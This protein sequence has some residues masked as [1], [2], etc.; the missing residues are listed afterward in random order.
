MCM[1]LQTSGW[2]ALFFAAKQ[3]NLIIV[4]ELIGG[5]ASV[6]I[7][8]K[9]TESVCLCELERDWRK[10]VGVGSFKLSS[11]IRM[12]QQLTMF[13][14]CMVTSLCVMSSNSTETDVTEVRV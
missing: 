14:S 12:K 13:P 6:D 1:C 2:T 4:Q 11:S 5:G 3:G 9:V 8:D 7:K 10:R